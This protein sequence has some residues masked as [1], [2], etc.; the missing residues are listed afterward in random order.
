MKVFISIMALVVFLILSTVASVYMIF[1]LFAKRKT[2]RYY[3]VLRN[4][5]ASMS[6]CALISCLCI[7][8]FPCSGLLYPGL[9]V[10]VFLLD[11]IIYHKDMKVKQELE[12]RKEAFL[13]SQP[14]DVEYRELN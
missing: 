9:S 6:V 14:I 2:P 10:P 4:L 1:H 11:A 8:L 13:K 5:F 3:K 7:S 12:E